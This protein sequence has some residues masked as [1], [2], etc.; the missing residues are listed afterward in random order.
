M[1]SNEKITCSQIFYNIK[2]EI[3]E[4]IDLQ[5]NNSCKKMC[6][7]NDQMTCDKCGRSV[8]EVINKSNHNVAI[9]LDDNELK[10]HGH[11]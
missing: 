10:R 7:I 3:K 4:P 8:F 1:N 11:D 2:A 9:K 6:E 5:K